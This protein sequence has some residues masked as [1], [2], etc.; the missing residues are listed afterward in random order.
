MLFKYITIYLIFS[1]LIHTSFYLFL[2]RKKTLV[3]G[4]NP[5]LLEDDGE[6]KEDSDWVTDNDSVMS[7]DG[8]FDE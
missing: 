2:K 5:H 1:K 8:E 3:C 4:S 7:D 6:D